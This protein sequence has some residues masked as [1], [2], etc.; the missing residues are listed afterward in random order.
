VSVAIDRREFLKLG[1]FAASAH[2]TSQHRWRFLPKPLA[3]AGPAKK[4]LVIQA[5][6]DTRA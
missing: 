1:V 4:I 2:L 6:E 3:A 5:P